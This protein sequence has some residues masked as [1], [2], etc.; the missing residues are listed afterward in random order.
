MMAMLCSLCFHS[1]TH[2][3]GCAALYVLQLHALAVDNANL[4]QSLS[5]HEQKSQIELQDLRKLCLANQDKFSYLDHGLLGGL[6]QE[7]QKQ[8]DRIA[9]LET[10]LNDSHK[11]VQQVQNK[12]HQVHPRHCL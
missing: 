3:L 7:H 2:C 5:Q 11:L 12:L 8:Q 6:Q 1:I 4:R 10:G 9:A